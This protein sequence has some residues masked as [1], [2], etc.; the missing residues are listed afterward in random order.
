MS[1]VFSFLNSFFFYTSVLFLK[2]ILFNTLNIIFAK[3]KYSKKGLLTN[4]DVVYKSK[5]QTFY[6]KSKLQIQIEKNIE[7]P[8]S[9]TLK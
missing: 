1:T 7:G 5:R 2:C 9:S 3:P 6:T 8:G 4:Y